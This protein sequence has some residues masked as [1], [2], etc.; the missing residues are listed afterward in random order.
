V[1][2]VDF[3]PSL[4]AAFMRLNYEWLERYFR[5]EEVDRR[6]LAEPQSELI[7][8]GGYILFALKNG[9]AVGTVALKHHGAGRFELTKMAV[10]ASQQGQGIGRALLSAAIERF[11]RIGGRALFLESHSSLKT[12]IKLYA[13][14]GFRHAAR[15][16][17]SDYAR[18]DTYM[19]YDP[20]LK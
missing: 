3:E 15:S 18:S 19:I 7:D 20:K 8:H 1:T 14:A 5:V 2:I 6:I 4:A 16:G 11:D 10:T 17:T 9:E 13:A 12:A